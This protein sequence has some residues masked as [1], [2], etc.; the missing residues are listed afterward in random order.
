MILSRVFLM[1]LHI[2]SRNAEISGFRFGQSNLGT[3]ILWTIHFNIGN[4]AFIIL[5][6]LSDVFAHILVARI[7]WTVVGIEK[8]LEVLARS[9][10]PS[11][12]RSGG[13]CASI[14]SVDLRKEFF[15]AVDKLLS[16]WVNV[17]VNFF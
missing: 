14:Q 10:K 16:C 1:T 5:Y 17:Q 13:K 8:L 3:T 6:T 4:P 15:T 7:T 9:T 2:D 12:M 11:Q